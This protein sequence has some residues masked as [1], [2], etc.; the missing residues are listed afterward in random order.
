MVVG[1]EGM[2]GGGW[3]SAEQCSGGA[4][5]CGCVPLK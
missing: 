4:A 5:E 3:G 2:C 1:V